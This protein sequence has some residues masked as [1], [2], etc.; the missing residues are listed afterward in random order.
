[1]EIG[2]TEIYISLLLLGLPH[3]EQLLA[4]LA[5][6]LPRADGVVEIP[7]PGVGHLRAALQLAHL[8]VNQLP[9]R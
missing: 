9:L 6:G 5:A 2:G 8:R 7:D 1:M 4:V 3:T